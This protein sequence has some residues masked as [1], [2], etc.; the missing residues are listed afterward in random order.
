MYLRDQRHR[1]RRIDAAKA[2]QPSDGLAICFRLA[3]FFKLTVEV[4][5]ALGQLLD[6]EQVLLEHELVRGQLELQRPQPP[7][8]VFTSPSQRQSNRLMHYFQRVK[9]KFERLYKQQIKL[10]KETESL[11]IFNN[12]A[13]IYSLPNN[14]RT[15]E[16]IDCSRGIID[17]AGNFVGKEGMDIYESLMGSLGA[18]GGS[19][20]VF[21]KPRGRT[22]MFWNL[23]DPHGDFAGKF[24]V[25]NMNW[26]MRA[27]EDT[28]YGEA[29]AEQKSR[30]TSHG[31][32]ENYMCEFMDE[33]ILLFPYELIDKQIRLIK[34]W[35]LAKGREQTPFPIYGG[36]DFGKKTSQTA[37][38]LVEH[39]DTKTIVKF[40]EVTQE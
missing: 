13:E 15:I 39:S 23:A 35:T 12:L 20:I 34:L 30:L 18:K 3:E 24:S 19:L 31:F 7:V 29:V 17:E 21:G 2:P 22:G 36:C 25:H 8:V 28:K 33:G 11:M 4:L 27:K 32:A 1:C 16:G 5:S 37:I 10:R 26:L 40:H 9:S 14:P 38:T 6:G